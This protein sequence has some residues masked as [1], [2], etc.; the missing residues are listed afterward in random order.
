MKNLLIGLLMLV[1][2]NV[3]AEKIPEPPSYNTTESMACVKGQL[4][5]VSKSEVH[6]LVETVFEYNKL[7]KVW[8]PRKCKEA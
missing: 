3:M 5:A 6:V 8:V 2:T 4:Y 1:T 7:L